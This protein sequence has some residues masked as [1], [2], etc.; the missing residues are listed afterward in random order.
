MKLSN[1]LTLI[2]EIFVVVF[3]LQFV[4]IPYDVCTKCKI[5][6]IDHHTTF[7]F[8]FLGIFF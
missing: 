3:G 6:T 5:I 2:L 8:S 7:R 4:K 1:C